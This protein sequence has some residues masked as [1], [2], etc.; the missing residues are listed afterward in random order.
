MFFREFFIFK[1]KIF[2]AQHRV[3]EGAWGSRHRDP[4]QG[5]LEP[6]AI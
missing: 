2:L 4:L 3:C 5:C 6:T 1:I